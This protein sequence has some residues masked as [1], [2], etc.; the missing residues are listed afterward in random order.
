MARWAAKYRSKWSTGAR[1]GYFKTGIKMH[2]L[3]EAYLRD[4]KLPAPGDPLADMFLSALPYMPKPKTGH[5]IE[6]ELVFHVGGVPFLAKP[7]WKGDLPGGT[8][9]IVDA[10]TTK[11]L[12]YALRDKDA[13]AADPQSMLYLRGLA[14]GGGRMTHIYMQKTRAVLIQE[15]AKNAHKGPLSPRSKEVSFDFTGAEVHSCFEPHR[16]RGAELYQ[17]R[18]KHEV[19]DPHQF[20]K[21]TDLCYEYGRQC[22]FLHECQKSAPVFDFG[23]DKPQSAF[24][25][26]E[27]P[28]EVMMA[29]GITKNIPKAVEFAAPFQA[30][31]VETPAAPAPAAPAPAV[32]ETPEAPVTFTPE[33]V[34]VRLGDVPIT[35]VASDERVDRTYN[36]TTDALEAPTATGT[37][38][39]ELGRAL[40]LLIQAFKA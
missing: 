21:N 20:S 14:E 34:E 31:K 1:P 13:K 39:A 17:L 8:P 28:K 40:R 18:N 16:A 10:K 30:P 23:L 4:G 24:T 2:A 26:F 33:Q 12:R 32:V 5:L 25:G 29:F 35:G 3:V 27:L 7:D 19:L 22:D 9:W 36:G 38:D 37:S 6:E 11:A 15:G